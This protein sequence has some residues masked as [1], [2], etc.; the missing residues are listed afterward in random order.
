M[1]CEVDLGRAN[2]HRTMYVR[3]CLAECTS[4]RICRSERKLQHTQLIH[5]CMYCLDQCTKIFLL[6]MSTYTYTLD[7]SFALDKI[8]ISA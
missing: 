4:T 3:L 6:A 7:S 5:T 2:K 8:S 1:I